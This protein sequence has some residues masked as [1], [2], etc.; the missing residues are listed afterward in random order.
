ML[1]GFQ[2]AACGMDT[3]AAVGEVVVDEVVVDDARWVAA[4][5][6]AFA[7]DEFR[8]AAV[9]GPADG[10]PWPVDGLVDIAVPRR[11]VGLPESTLP[12][13]TD[14]PA[15]S[16]AS[17]CA[18][19]ARAS[20]EPTPSAEPMPSAAASVLMRCSCDATRDRVTAAPFFYVCREFTKHLVRLWR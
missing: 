17:A 11:L 2:V 18:V 6:E 5:A 15:E 19:A 13:D 8:F 4:T 14:G 12:A 1:P 10:R 9:G 20:A 7:V 16:A 3:A